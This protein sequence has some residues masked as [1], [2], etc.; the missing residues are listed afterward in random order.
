MSSEIEQK[1]VLTNTRILDAIGNK[2][3]A[4][5][6][7]VVPGNALITAFVQGAKWW[8]YHKTGGTMWQSDQQIVENEAERRLENSTLGVRRQTHEE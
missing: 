1:D 8:E 3:D 4:A 7:G 6:S 5:A 2:T